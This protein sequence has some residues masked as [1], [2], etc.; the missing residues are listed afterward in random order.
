MP[1]NYGVPPEEVR[2]A[3]E[4]ERE[5]REAERRSELARRKLA[6]E[7][8][9]SDAYMQEAAHHDLARQAYERANLVR[10]DLARLLREAPW[11]RD[12]EEL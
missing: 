4:A 11:L 10:V 9:L 7:A 12:A 8:D 1:A 6:L 5:R 2:Q 3:A